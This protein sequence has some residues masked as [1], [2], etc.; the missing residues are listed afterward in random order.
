MRPQIIPFDPEIHD[1][2]AIDSP[3]PNFKNRYKKR[4]A[5]TI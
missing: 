5:F 3:F 1:G 4:S 2:V